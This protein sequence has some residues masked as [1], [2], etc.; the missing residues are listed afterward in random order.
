MRSHVK[1]QSQVGS[2]QFPM[3]CW[4]HFNDKLLLPQGQKQLLHQPLNRASTQGYVLLSLENLNN[5]SQVKTPGAPEKLENQRPVQRSVPGPAFSFRLVHADPHTETSP[6][7]D[8]LLVN[9]EPCSS[10]LDACLLPLPTDHEAFSKVS[11]D[12]IFTRAEVQL[13]GPISLLEWCPKHYC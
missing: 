5:R 9:H 13:Y 12:K 11:L 10:F 4:M 3:C 8:V 1:M 6:C 7:F 2:G